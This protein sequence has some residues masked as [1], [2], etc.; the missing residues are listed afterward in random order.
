MK[1]TILMHFTVVYPANAHTAYEIAADAFIELAERG[2]NAEAE[3]RTDEE[4]LIL[5][6]GRPRAASYAKS[7]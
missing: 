5:A 1:E 3:K 4:Y 2:G 6:G 7:K